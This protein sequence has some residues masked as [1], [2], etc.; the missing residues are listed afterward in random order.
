MKLKKVTYIFLIVSMLA[1]NFVTNMVFPPPT[2]TPVPTATLTVT[3]SPTATLEPLK[4]SYIPPQCQ[5]VVPA[6]VSPE[7]IL[8][9]PTS[10]VPP[11]TEISQDMQLEIFENMTSLIT[12]VYLYP[13]FNGKDWEGIVAKYRAD[14]EAG[15]STEEFYFAM[16]NMVMDL[17]DEHSSFQPPIVVE[18]L[19]SELAGE[20][21]FVGVGIYIQPQMDKEQVT[22][23]SVMP[24]SPAEYSGLRAHDV[25]LTVDDHPIVKDGELFINLV[26]GL[27]CSATV[28]TVKS[29]G[30]EARKVMLI[31][32]RIQGPANIEARLVPTTDGSRIGYIF[33]PTF[34]DRTIPRQIEDALNEFGVL[35]G[36][37]LD[38]RMNGGGS[39]DV[40]EPILS[41]FTAGTLGSFVSRH[42]SHPFVI[43]PDSVNF[44]Q[45]VPLVILVGEGT[46]SFG[47]IFSGA[48]QDNGRAKIVG[49]TTMGNVETLHGY[50][51][52]DGSRIWIAEEKFDPAVSHAN[53]E[54]TGI[55]PDVEAFADWDT[56]VFET[57]PAILAALTLLGH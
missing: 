24:N 30:E 22:L 14:V 49:Q 1:C 31:R 35:D 29:P 27:E 47:E 8:A 19:N 50:G 40:V 46:A 21:E 42:E 5:G 6:T 25:I 28:L 39:S 2:A 4:A 9:Q 54:E 3:A 48:L 17:G 16:E 11:N 33:I 18:E 34:F 51:F 15:L 10:E 13:D 12:D 43:N 7:T 20:N 57:D 55:I 26:R 23:I 44:S 41:F 38:N 56:F 53:W 37:I 45:D 52:D 32:E 36:L